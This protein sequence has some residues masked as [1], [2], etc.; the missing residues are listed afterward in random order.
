MRTQSIVSLLAAASAVVAQ[1]AP[2]V[3]NNPIGAQY[4][5]LI[6][7][8]APYAVSGSVKIASGAAGKGVTIEVALANLPTEGGPF[9]YHIHEKAVP[10][11]GNCTA[12]G[13][14]LDPY[15]RGEV[16]ACDASNP[17]SCQTGDLSGKHGNMTQ[18]SFSAT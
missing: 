15:K 9:M 12:T 6:K 5:A 14:H 18:T 13:A 3:K 1:D 4:Q 7:G 10:E 8:K 16:P 11:N 2:V 17:K